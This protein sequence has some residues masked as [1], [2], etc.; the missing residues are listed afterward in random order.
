MK[1]YRIAGVAWLALIMTAPAH[2]QWAG[3][4]ALGWVLARGNTDTDTFNAAIDASDTVGDWKYVMGGSA[5]QATSSGTSTAD[6][7][8]LYGGANYNLNARSYLLGMLRYDD[9]HFSPYAYSANAALG[10]GYKFIDDDATKLAAEIGPGY[11]RQK[12]RVTGATEGDAIARG[13]INFEHSFNS[14]TKITDKFLIEAGSNNTFTQNDLGLTV[15][16][17]TSLALMVDYQYRHNSTLPPGTT[18]FSKTDQLI[19][20]SLVF[21]FGPQPTGP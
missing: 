7:Y 4:G 17:A 13:A 8:Q 9:D 10:Y 18:N 14:A 11:R 21:A 12:D 2:A 20:T 6:R 16:M 15:K 5:L 19:T 1:N 3:K